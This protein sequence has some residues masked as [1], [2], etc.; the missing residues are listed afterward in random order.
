MKQI[1]CCRNP[2]EALCDLAAREKW[3]WQIIC[4]TCGHMHFRYSF[5]ELCLGKHPDSPGW[6]AG[7]KGHPR[8]NDLLGPMPPLAALP[9][10]AQKRLTALLSGAS[11]KAICSSAL[12]PDWLGYLGLGLLYCADAERQNRKLTEAWTP[13]L[14]AMVRAAGQGCPTMVD[15]EL[16]G[17]LADPLRRMTWRDLEGVEQALL[18]KSRK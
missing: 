17:I 16:T 18:A 10:D 7:R 12:F 8:L 3:C 9:L 1:S 14:S 11:L 5:L 15:E 2:F 4:T 6:L 13:Q